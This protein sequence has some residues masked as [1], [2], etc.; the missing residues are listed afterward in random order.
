VA[1]SPGVSVIRAPRPQVGARDAA[2]VLA[3]GALRGWE[4]GRSRRNLARSAAGAAPP[5]APRSYPLMVTVHLALF[6]VPLVRRW[7][8]PSPPVPLRLG[9]LAVL[10]AATALRAW[11]IASLGSA[12][13]VEARVPPALVPVQRGPY[14]FCRHPNYLAVTAEFLALPAFLGAAREAAW[15]SAGNLLVLWPRVRGEER[16]LLMI[17]AYRTAFATTPRFIPRLRRPGRGR[18]PTP[19]GG[20]PAPG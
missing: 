18:S 10:G 9:S 15:L 5:A 8:R 3:L 17:P 13:N 12:W 7:H 20:P 14:R 2:V 16:R 19:R 1:G 4:L 6:T 11:S